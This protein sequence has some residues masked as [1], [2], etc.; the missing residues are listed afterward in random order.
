MDIAS[1]PQ[2]ISTVGFPI[3]MCLSM[4]WYIKDI[5]E[6]RNL[7]VEKF[8]NAINRNTIILQKLY[9]KFKFDLNLDE[10]EE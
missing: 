3:V 7:E 6:K 4:L 2:L 10:R 9:D 1:L 8:T 5:T